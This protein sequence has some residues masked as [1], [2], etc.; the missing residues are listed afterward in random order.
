LIIDSHALAA[1]YFQN[2]TKLRRTSEVFKGKEGN[3]EVPV[4]A[5]NA[6]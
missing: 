6:P 4:E 2:Y 1:K 3:G 5:E